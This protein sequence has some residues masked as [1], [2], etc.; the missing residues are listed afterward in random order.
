[1]HFFANSPVFHVRNIQTPVLILHN[2]QDDAVPWYQGIELYLSM[3]RNNKEAYLFN[4]NGEKHG[5]RKRP[6]QKDWTVRMQ[7]FFD[8]HLKDGPKPAWMEK[9]IPF[10]ERE[11]SF[12]A[13][14][15]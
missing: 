13:S 2:D 4:Y 5:I 8:H 9:G 15:R 6:N 7:Q 12:A 1:M 3:R 14:D 11:R 10:I